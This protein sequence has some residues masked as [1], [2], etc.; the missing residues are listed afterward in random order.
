MSLEEERIKGQLAESLRNNSLLKEIFEQLKESY[1]TDWSQTDLNDVDAREHSFYL[2][3]VL[4][5]IETQIESHISTGKI[6]T[7]QI[8]SIVRKK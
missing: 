3:R 5:D 6:A 1:I 8:D 7:K 4:S 2:L